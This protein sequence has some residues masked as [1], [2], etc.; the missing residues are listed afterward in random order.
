MVLAHKNAPQQEANYLLIKVNWDNE[1][2]QKFLDEYSNQLT[3]DNELFERQDRQPRP[4]M[5]PATK[6]PSL[7]GLVS[8]QRSIS[9]E[10]ITSFQRR[11]FS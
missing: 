2:F 11:G 8:L 3:N 6:E 4:Y 5:Q 1:E 9:A 7:S 10:Y